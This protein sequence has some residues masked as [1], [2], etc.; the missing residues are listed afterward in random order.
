MKHTAHFLFG[1]S[2]LFTALLSGCSHE[3]DQKP[4]GAMGGGMPPP[5][6]NVVTVATGAATVTQDLPGRLVAYKT[7]QVRA[8]VDG[9]VEKR[10]YLEGSDVKAGDPL[11]RIDARSYRATYDAAKADTEVAR[12]IAERDK[13]LLD[14]KAL[15]QQDYDLAVAKVKQAEAVLAKAALD[16][17]NT[18]VPAPISG[19]IGRAQVTE[20]ALVG[21]GDA[22]LLATIE[23]LDPIYV[24]F[25]QPSTDAMRLKHALKSGKLKRSGAASVSLILDNGKTYAHEG[26]L[27]FSDL[28]VDPDTGNI[29]M[30]AKFPN[31]GHGLLPGMFVTIRLAEGSTDNSIRLPQRAVQTGPQGQFVML[32]A[33][34]KT[35]PRPVR[36]DGMAGEDFII[37]DGVKPGDQVIVDGLQKARPGAPVKP[38]PL[39]GT[40]AAET[41]AAPAGK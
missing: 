30:R 31:P 39:G 9:I 3:D 13:S 5:E 1:T 40:P 26:K 29:A 4:P 10:Q 33:D 27:L 2:L 32:V 36:T 15:S 7:A 37:A 22:T 21:H 17:E 23:Q 41:A 18:L 14:A 25:T 16:L 8:R 6:V 35:T 38:V 20:G 28:A 12:Q 34:G 24:D 11:F 19:R